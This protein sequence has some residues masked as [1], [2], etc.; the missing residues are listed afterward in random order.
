MGVGVGVGVGWGVDSGRDEGIEV[1]EEAGTEEEIEVEVEAVSITGRKKDAAVEMEG[2]I[3][4]LIS[5]FPVIPSITLSL[6]P[7]SIIFS[8]ILSTNLSFF[9]STTCSALTASTLIS[10]SFSSG[11]LFFDVML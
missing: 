11:D 3:F 9:F 8:T 1:E 10:I 6:S 2:R 4:L 5:F 7:F